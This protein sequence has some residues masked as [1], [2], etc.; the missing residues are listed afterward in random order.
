[1]RVCSTVFYQWDTIPMKS[2]FRFINWVEG[3]EKPLE[4]FLFG[5]RLIRLIAIIVYNVR[6]LN[7]DRLHMFSKVLV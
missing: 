6:I 2:L 5:V 1:M 4:L 3:I 7:K